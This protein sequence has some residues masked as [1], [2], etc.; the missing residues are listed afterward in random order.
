MKEKF[1]VLYPLYLL[2]NKLINSLFL[3]ANLEVLFT[4]IFLSLQISIISS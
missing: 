3:E 1:A 4:I 2:M